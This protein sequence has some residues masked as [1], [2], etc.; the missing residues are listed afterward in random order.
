MRHGII[1]H[2]L[3]RLFI[4]GCYGASDVFYSEEG[5]LLQRKD[6]DIE[7]GIVYTHLRL[8]LIETFAMFPTSDNY[9]DFNSRVATILE[10]QLTKRP[11][12]AV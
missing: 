7:Q 3:V 11:V 4:R 2:T 10:K 8:G 6:W 9:C 5:I 1:H 12:L